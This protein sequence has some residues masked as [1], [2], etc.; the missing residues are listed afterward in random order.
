VYLTL[1]EGI[2]GDVTLYLNGK[3]ADGILTDDNRFGPVLTDGSMTVA[4]EADLPWGRVKSEDMP[5][6]YNSVV[7]DFVEV[8]LKEDLI[9]TVYKTLVEYD[10]AYCANIEGQKLYKY[11]YGY[12]EDTNHY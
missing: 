12:I 6:T 1:P 5:I 8:N 9:E 2:D 10:V 11:Y 7:V 3:K 4:V